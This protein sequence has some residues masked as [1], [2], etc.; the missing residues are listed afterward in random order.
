MPRD[1]RDR[2]IVITG[3]SAG[4]GAATALHCASAGMKVMLA[5]RRLDRL[6][7]VRH[8]ITA[9]GGVAQAMVCDVDRD[10]DVQALVERTR[11]SFGR[12]D[13]MFANAG[14]G[15]FGSVLDAPE[16]QVRTLF[17]TN[18][19][20][21]LRCLRAAVPVMRA[22]VKPPQRGHLL[23]CTS[24]ASEVPVPCYG[25]Y[26]ATKAAQ[27]SIGG[28]MRTELADDHIDVTTVHPV[29]TV[30]EFNE[31][32]RQHNPDAGDGLNTPRFMLQ[33]A[34]H[35][36]RSIV[37]CL[38]RPKPEVWPSVGARYGVALL[39]AFPGLAAL[40]NRR[41]HGHRQCNHESEPLHEHQ[42]EANTQSQP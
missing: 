12:L 39:T 1:L 23:I 26:T 5:A 34:D 28:A 6:E 17:E 38:R 20:G 42:P 3:A 11:E 4:I 9:A 31:V 32:I 2:V 22:T 37:Q 29:G 21:T 36:A 41:I 8:Q 15:L 13:V 16:Q 25:F 33:T 40:V 19:Y 24:A 10:E 30:T 18:F 7:Q 27:D 14:Y 35:V